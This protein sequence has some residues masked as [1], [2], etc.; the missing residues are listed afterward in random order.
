[1]NKVMTFLNEVMIQLAIVNSELEHAIG[2]DRR[3][4]EGARGELTNLIWTAFQLQRDT[5][6]ARLQ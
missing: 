6:P 1:M 3:A 4:L 2:S 5:D